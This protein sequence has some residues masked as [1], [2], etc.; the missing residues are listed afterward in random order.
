M[1]V[2]VVQLEEKVVTMTKEKDA[3]AEQFAQ[4]CGKAETSETRCKQVGS[5]S[6]SL[7]HSR[8]PSGSG[9]QHE[10]RNFRKSC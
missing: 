7:R 10:R 1:I 5:R 2:Q 3:L 6:E 9:I 8:H 4:E